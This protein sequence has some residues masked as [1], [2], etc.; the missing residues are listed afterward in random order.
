MEL[1]KDNWIKGGS[2]IID[3]QTPDDIFT[4][5]DFSEEQRMMKEAVQ[6][7][8]DREV[9]PNKDRFEKKDYALTEELMEKIGALGFLG[10]SVPEAYGGLGMD[11]VSTML[12]C[13]YISGATGS[14]STA[15]GAHTGI[16]TLPITLYGTEEQKQK[17]V[18]KLATGEWFGS[19][20][21]TEPGAGS[22]ANSGKTKAVLSDDG[23]HYLISGQ[24]M[25]ISNAGFA[26]V[27]IVFARIED[28]KNITGFIVPKDDANG[29]TFG[30]EENKLGIHS[31][32]TRQV[33]FSETKVP[34]E[35]MLAGRGEG[36]KIAMNALNVGRIKLGVACLDAQR[37]ITS[38]A[39]QYANERIQ[40][41]TP[42]AQF[43]AIKEKLAHMA[44]SCYAGESA[45]YRAAYD[46]EKR[47]Q[48]FVAEG[49]THQ[50][51]ELKGVEDFAIEC[52]LLKV[53]ASEDIQNA[54]DHGIQIMGGMG[55]SAD[56]PMES[57]WRDARIGRIYEGTNEINRMLSVGMLLKKGMKGQLDLMS[58][59]MK[60]ATSI[61][62]DTN[63]PTDRG[64]ILA[65]ERRLLANFKQLFIVLT[66]NAAQ[67]YGAKLDEHQQILLALSDI[68]IE[69]Y[70]TESAIL[71]TLKNCDCSGE[72]SQLVQIAMAKAYLYEASD[73]I[74]KKGKEV[75]IN[76]CKEDEQKQLLEV[77]YKKLQF[78]EYSD[79]IGLKTQIADKLIEENKYCF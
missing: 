19:Y 73:I 17:Y 66:G 30:D 22:D 35:N 38:A 24:K 28:D 27:F 58:A 71:R 9:W 16:G 43:G 4:P 31:S 74:A 47:I 13:D 40:F 68:F 75:I 72:K 44:T 5:E 39:V 51:A 78:K 20:C 34:V 8:I 62:E 69:I 3:D 64:S 6:E 37:R 70:F 49:L 29:I 76:M 50:E 15:F 33:F 23:T 63:I 41:N 21:L 67:K 56:M 48:S 46:V 18:T 54:A 52:S 45:C 59:V 1:K 36:F 55:F 14:L 65:E 32:S 77:L 26:S 12:V 79:I 7:F 10:V 61:K 25:W 2:F 53:G 57:A 42:I 11:F 60:A